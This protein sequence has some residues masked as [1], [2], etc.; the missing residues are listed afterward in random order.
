MTSR[1]V[2]ACVARGAEILN[3]AGIESPRRE[4]RLLLAHAAGQS[5]EWI[6][7]HPEAACGVA[8]T[9][10]GLIER[11]RAREPFSY[12]VGAR[13]FWSLPFR[14]SADVLDPRADSET[15][16]S[17]A[18][19][20]FPA[21]DRPL[22]VLDLGTGSGCLLLA[23]L[24]ER[25]LAMGIGVDRSPAALTVAR[26]NACNLGLA[27]R[28]RFL[29]AD[30]AQ[31]LSGRFDLILANP[32]YIPAAD[33][34]GLSPEVSRYE[35]RGALDGGADGLDCYRAIAAQLP[36]VAD[37]DTRLVLEFGIGQAPSV[38][39]IFQASGFTQIEMISDLAGLPR[40]LVAGGLTPA[41]A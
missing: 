7:A 8:D 24:H 9:Y 6:V 13:E 38:S 20:C 4:A 21:R 27:G 41:V 31:G 2:G 19:T 3:G 1:S 29:C 28:A 37:A 23:F 33:I 5:F 25:S 10:D 22:R 26:E 35:P 36:V 12:I 16:V 32:P 15:L 18:L 17:A 30:W 11:R 40:C 14:V 34:A 39:R